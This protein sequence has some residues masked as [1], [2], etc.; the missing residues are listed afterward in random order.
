MERCSYFIENKALF[1]SYP[2]QETVKYLEN[3]GVICFVDLTNSDEIN[4]TSYNTSK[5]YIKYPIV[6]RKIPENW[7]TFAKLIIDCCKIIDNLKIGEKIY[8]HCKGGHGRSGIVVA[9]I[10]CYYNNISVEESLRKT[11]KYHSER[12]FMKEKWRKI[13]SPQGKKQKD[14]VYKYFKHLKYTDNN[15]N[16][17]I[18]CFSN[19]SKHSVKTELGTF[20]TAYFAYQAY[21]RANDIE[22]LKK[23]QKGIYC[24]VDREKDW[25]RNR[26]K[27]MYNVLKNKF[28]QHPEIKEML[29][30]TGLRPLIKI[31]Q[32]NFWGN[33]LY[34]HG[35]NIHGKLLEKIRLEFLKM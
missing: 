24:D 35:K 26:T 21:K 6:D 9:C 16:D 10:L 3:M 25:E 15:F 20:P 28:T 30:I 2:N 14:F 13:G 12:I 1:G 31:S 32:D 5:Q 34:G 4:I 29:L 19:N 8:I 23:L 18:N 33:G 17:N 22:Y 7:V 11:N 27:F